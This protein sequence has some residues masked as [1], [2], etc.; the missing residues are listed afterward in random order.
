MGQSDRAVAFQRVSFPERNRTWPWW[1]QCF[2][3]MPGLDEEFGAP[4]SQRHSAE[5][6]CR[7]EQ[8]SRG[9]VGRL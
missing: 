1:W 8:L 6:R 3:S 5:L 4:S 2:L 9:Q 7:R